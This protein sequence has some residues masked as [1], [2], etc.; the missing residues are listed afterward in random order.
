ME[1]TTSEAEGKRKGPGPLLFYIMLGI[2]A[3]SIVIFLT[4]SPFH[5]GG[6]SKKQAVPSSQ[7]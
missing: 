6:G 3:A 5:G 7:H 1:P 4:L 2:I